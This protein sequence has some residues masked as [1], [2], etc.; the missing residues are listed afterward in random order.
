VRRGRKH[1]GFI[2]ERGGILYARFK[3]NGV[4]YRESCKSSRMG[5]AQRVLERLRREVLAGTYL[6][7]RERAAQ[8]RARLE[9]ERASAAVLALGTVARL[10]EGWLSTY[11]ATRRNAKGRALATTRA[12][13]Y[14]VPYLGELQVAEVRPDHLR[15]YRLHLQRLMKPAKE[16]EQERRLLTDQTVAHVLSEARSFFSWA[17]EAGHV[18]RSPIPKKLLPSTPEREPKP[19]TDEQVALVN[20]LPDP[21]GFAFRL[22]IGTGVRWG[23]LVRLKS[24]D[25]RDGALVLTAPK[26]NKL[27]RIPVRPELLAEIRTHVGLLV[28]WGEE[29]KQYHVFLK[30]AR[31]LAGFKLGAH[32]GRH[33]FAF[34]WVWDGGSLATLQLAMGHA[35]IETTMIYAKPTDALVQR[36][37]ERM[38]GEEARVTAR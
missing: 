32:Q 35:S 2:E 8:E 38:W 22:M 16:G 5:D 27:R 13:K 25:V 12:R 34:R 33:T 11:V 31:K 23:E 29:P 26:T 28:P 18:A 14:L 19:F 17:L 36:E 6:P 21:F 24:A 3:H 9:A 30:A 10:V 4:R 15:E 7:P 37:A 20:A 1:Q